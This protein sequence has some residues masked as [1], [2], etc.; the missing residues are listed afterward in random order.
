MADRSWRWR[1][2]IFMSL[3]RHHRGLRRTWSDFRAICRSQDRL[4]SHEFI[5]L[6]I[7]PVLH[8][9]IVESLGLSATTIFIKGVTSASLGGPATLRL[10]KLG[11][12][13]HSIVASKP[14]LSDRSILT[15]NFDFREL[16]PWFRAC[17]GDLERDVVIVRMNAEGV[18][19]GIVSW[20][21][22]S[23]DP[24]TR[25]DV[26]MGSLGDIRKCFGPDAEAQARCQLS[27]ASIPFI[28]FTSS[29]G[30]WRPALEALIA[31]VRAKVDSGHGLA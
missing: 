12:L 20:L 5:L 26:L 10:A 27:S 2:Q 6:L 19:K 4:A 15:H 14:N 23:G 22:S 31:L 1:I 21:T 24:Q 3:T 18:E 7:E 30:S 17:I 9:E 8:R 29:P 25:C 11:D 28:Y 16:L 13:G